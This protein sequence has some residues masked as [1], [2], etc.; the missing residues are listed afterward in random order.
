MKLVLIYDRIINFDESSLVARDIVEYFRSIDSKVLIIHSCNNQIT[1]G[2]YK[3][4]DQFQ[5]DV[6]QLFGLVKFKASR[7]S[8]QPKLVIRSLDASLD[9]SLS[10][11]YRWFK[12]I[13]FIY[14]LAKKSAIRRSQRDVAL[15][16]SSSFDHAQTLRKNY[17]ISLPVAIVPLKISANKP[18]ITTINR[19]K[20]EIGLAVRQRLILARL[21]FNHAVEIELVLKSLANFILANN[22]CQLVLIGWGRYSTRL[23][24][25][26]ARY[27]L[28]RSVINLGNVSGNKLN[29]LILASEVVIL[30]SQID[31]HDSFASRCISLG[32]P[33]ITP[34]SQHLPSYLKHGRNA[35]IIPP[36]DKS[37]SSALAYIISN[38]KIKR[39]ISRYCQ[40]SASQNQNAPVMLAGLYQKLLI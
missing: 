15:L 5:P 12:F 40:I 13:P 18:S 28:E 25:Y 24:R 23:E 21:D 33:I 22:Q 26:I 27:R 6:V 29:K 11:K 8:G 31:Q 35:L 30:P 19:L 14:Q 38:R 20:K 3:L 39:Q 4:I 36:D 9:L 7:L 2:S 16:L 32:T 1:E 34:Q 17:E 10:L 37:L